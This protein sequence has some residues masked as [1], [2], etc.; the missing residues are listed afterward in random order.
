M[1]SPASNKPIIVVDTREQ[2]PYSFTD[3]RVGSVVNTALPAGDYS[4]QGYETR[5]A[6]E[7][8]SLADYVSTVVHAQDR[9]SREL[10]ILRSYPRAWIVVEASM[11]DVLQGRY[12]SEVKPQALFA[13]T[14]A[15][16]VIYGIEVQFAFDRP[17]AR[18]WVEELL[19]QYWKSQQKK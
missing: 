11:D 6:I 1:A 13:M 16:Q 3:D 2:R 5:I 15:L 18:A 8:K 14:A 17:T 10:S 7:R 12:E 9:F 19:V 4:L